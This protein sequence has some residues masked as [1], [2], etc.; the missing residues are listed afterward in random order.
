MALSMLP[1]QEQ[2]LL[3]PKHWI[4]VVLENAGEIPHGLR[5]VPPGRSGLTDSVL[6]GR[7]FV[8]RKGTHLTIEK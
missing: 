3:G 4:A 1:E 8:K 2:G 5:V 6:P 7:V